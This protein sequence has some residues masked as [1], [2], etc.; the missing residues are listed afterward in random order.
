MPFP[1]YGS[2][3]R[4][5]RM[6]AATWPTCSLLYPLITTFVCVSAAIVIPCGGS[7]SIGC[8]YPSCSTSFLPLIWARYPVPWIS[9]TL[10][11]PFVTPST[12][13]ARTA[14]VV[15]WRASACL[16]PPTCA[17]RISL[18][19]S[20]TST[21]WASRNSSSPL[22][23]FTWIAW[24]RRFTCTPCGILIG[25]F[26]TRDGMVSL[27]PD[28]AKVLAAQPFVARFDIGHDAARRGDDGGPHAPLDFGYFVAA[29][30]HAASGLAH[31]LDP[32]DDAS[33]LGVILEIDA[34]NALLLVVDRLVVV[35]ELLLEEQPHELRLQIRSRNVH[36][37][38]LRLACVADARQEIRNGIANRHD[39]LSGTGRAALEPPAPPL[40]LPARLDHTRDLAQQG[41]LPETN[42]AEAEVAQE[43]ARTAAAVATVVA[44]HLELGRP[45]PLL[46]QGLL[47]QP[48]SFVVRP[49]AD[50]RA[51]S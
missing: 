21:P 28:A 10:E 18:G 17:T 8:E 26:P 9:S 32:L 51:C 23:P 48:R 5:S 7:Y 40:G 20:F 41:E 37:L 30:V 34:E 45:L 13:F 6:I 1:L 39:S 27:L 50:G 24:A 11:N 47:G 12:M 31:A 3:G 2:G 19:S 15:P 44:A 49:D 46:Y 16:P 4:K 36:L 35:D 38:V 14:R 42:A 22:G 29:Q 33:L 43:G 25:I